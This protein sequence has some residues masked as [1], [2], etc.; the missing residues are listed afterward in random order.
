MT[1][2][3]APARVDVLR[4]VL[5]GAA[6]GIPAA[7]AAIAFFTVVHYLEQLIWHALPTALG[8]A[9]PPWYLVV[10]LPVVGA[11]IVAI[12]RL[13]LPGDGGRSPLAGMSHGATPV[14][15]VPG[16]V[17]A[18]LGTLGFG[19]VLGPEAP[20]MAV[21]SAV[22]LAITSL[23]RSDARE[24]GVL[25]M[26]GI[27]SAISTLFGGP[28][29]AG[30]MLTEGGISMGAVLIPVLLPGFVAAAVGYLVFLGVGPYTGAPA[31]GLQV[32]DLPAY[33]GTSVPD[34]IIAIVVGVVTAALIVAINRAAKRVAAL[35]DGRQGDGRV[36]L[37]AALLLGGLAV[38]A[39]AQLA[40]VF[41]VAPDAV[42]FS[43]Q[44][45]IPAL[46]SESS[47][48]ALVVLVIAKAAAYAVSLATGFRGGP[49]FPAVFLGVG[50]AAFAV[51][52]FGTSP[53]F[54]IAI[55]CAAGMAAQT[56]LVVTSM[57]FAALLV[58]SG[59]FD[60]IAGAVFATVA[61]WLTVQA[62][63]P[64]AAAQPEGQSQPAPAG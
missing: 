31:P 4:L 57:L 56:R 5:L 53:T 23:V 34:L 18:A 32:P 52:L 7:L 50:V 26:A 40:T 37:V 55:G 24:Q 39:L 27:F 46:V 2:Q 48:I 63:D 38:G 47:L 20:V 15:Y 6:I 30:V 33:V 29:V 54:A 1:E 8:E 59:G 19:L 41:G 25:S 42:L 62:L 16:I 28:L 12:A 14:R 17:V 61:S 45:S 60:A 36:G 44:A 22:G 35:Q 58:G 9:S 43:G 49:I 3:G 51:E 13:T 10:F 11:A 64:P 21:G